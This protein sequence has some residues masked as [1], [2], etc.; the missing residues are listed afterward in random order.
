[1][2]VQNAENGK[3][4]IKVPWNAKKTQSIGGEEERRTKNK[5]PE[6]KLEK[7]L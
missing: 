4:C 6:K 1:V 3:R 7:H 2:L 5:I